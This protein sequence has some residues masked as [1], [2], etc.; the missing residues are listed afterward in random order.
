MNPAVQV[1]VPVY[2]GEA[3]LE[4]CLRSI[5]NQTYSNLD[6]VV[7]D[8]ASTDR[9]ASIVHAMDDPRIR[10]RYEAEHVGLAANLNRCMSAPDPGVPYFCIVHADDRL[11]PTYV[12]RVLAI[13]ETQPDASVFFTAGSLMDD[14]GRPVTRLQH[15]VRD[16]V[17]RLTPAVLAGESGLRLICT[18]NYLIAPTAFF[19]TARWMDGPGFDSRYT[20]IVDQALW[21]NALLRGHTFCHVKEA[22]YEHRVH[23]R[24]LS[25]DRRFSLSKYDEFERCR[26]MLQDVA[27]PEITPSLLRHWAFYLWLTGVRDALKDV[28][29]LQFRVAA[30]RLHHILLT[31]L[32]S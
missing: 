9:S 29:A 19:R 6:I 32:Q 30:R 22:L 13:A 15:R 7:I 3:F 25:A 1:F 8:N 23:R 14:D 10:Y 18:Y 12:E 28:S 27:P 2:N 21:I 4:E 11:V 16:L 24:Q 20:Y 5:L 26:T 17:F 31:S